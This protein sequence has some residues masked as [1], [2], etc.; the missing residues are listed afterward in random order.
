M[1]MKFTKQF[2]VTIHPCF[3]NEYLQGTNCN[4][5]VKQMKI[6]EN[7]WW[8]NMFPNIDYTHYM[9]KTFPIAQHGWT[10]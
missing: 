9:W 3:Q 7:K 1:D 6:N 10:T 2:V 8:P 5:H 4:W